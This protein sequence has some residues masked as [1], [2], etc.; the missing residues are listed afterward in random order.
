MR[1][2]TRSRGAGC[3]AWTGITPGGSGGAPS[4]A[5]GRHSVSAQ[6]RR[7]ASASKSAQRPSR[8]LTASSTR[9]VGWTSAASV[10]RS[11]S[12]SSGQ[13]TQSADSTTSHLREAIGSGSGCVQGLHAYGAART[14][15]MDE[16]L[17]P[18]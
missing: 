8:S 10:E 3:A 1:A 6:P 16:L 17:Q 7:A 11:G 9:V 18:W 5:C 15:V 2:H 14:I 13:K 4:S 12:K